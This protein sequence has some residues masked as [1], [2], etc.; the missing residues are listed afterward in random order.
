MRLSVDN[1]LRHPASLIIE[2]SC[3]I[4]NSDTSTGSILVEVLVRGVTPVRFEQATNKGP[5]YSV[6][7]GSEPETPA[8]S[9]H[10]LS[11]APFE[12]DLPTTGQHSMAKLLPVE[13]E[14]GRHRHESYES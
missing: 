5:L 12:S 14:L 3:K 10:N 6:I 8:V 13:V 4:R 1:A 9:R 11:N 2:I 7:C